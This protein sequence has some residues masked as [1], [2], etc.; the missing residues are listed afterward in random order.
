MEKGGAYEGPVINK[1][2]ERGE[3]DKNDPSKLPYLNKN[4]AI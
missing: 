3:L 2:N 4:P 1:L